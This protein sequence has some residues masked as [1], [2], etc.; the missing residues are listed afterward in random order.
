MDWTININNANPRNSFQFQIHLCISFRKLN[1][2]LSFYYL[3]NCN[4]SLLELVIEKFNIIVMKFFQIRRVSISIYYF[5]DAIFFCIVGSQKKFCRL[6]QHNNV[7][8]FLN[9][10]YLLHFLLGQQDLLKTSKLAFYYL[11]LQSFSFGNLMNKI[12]ILVAGDC[13]L[14]CCTV[15]LW[16]IL[17]QM[18]DFWLTWLFSSF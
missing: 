2:H 5:I 8:L 3:T 17:G 18:S 4:R 9:I 7:S 15:W 10:Y 11:N 13:T 16:Q 1:L 6:I 14:L 12:L